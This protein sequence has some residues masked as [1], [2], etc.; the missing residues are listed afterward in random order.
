[1]SNTDQVNIAFDPP[2]GVPATSDDPKDFLAPTPY[3]DFDNEP[4][5]AF[6]L[7]TVKGA[8]GDVEKAIKLFYAVRD[9]IRYN[10]Y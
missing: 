5:R 4:V 6:A 8:T 1:M 3:L 7:D 9:D 10:P 2:D